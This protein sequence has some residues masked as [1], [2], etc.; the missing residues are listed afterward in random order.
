MHSPSTASW[1]MHGLGWG[2]QPCAARLPE[3]GWAACVQDKLSLCL[4]AAPTC[5]SIVHLPSMAPRLVAAQLPAPG[6][7]LLPLTRNLAFITC[8]VDLG[9]LDGRCTTLRLC[10]MG[11]RRPCPCP[12]L[13]TGSGNAWTYD[14]RTWLGADA[15]AG[16]A[17]QRLR[18]PAG[19]VALPDRMQADLVHYHDQ[20][21]YPTFVEP[22][23]TG[24]TLTH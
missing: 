14:G 6:A 9:E 18:G 8:S 3:D 19:Q 7:A 15:L 13:A 12:S 5:T 16:A 23:S 11:P 1:G 21:S 20:T 24:R 4:L 2:V 22:R 17:H 10:F